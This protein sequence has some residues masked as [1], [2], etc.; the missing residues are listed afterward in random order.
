[1]PVDSDP[2]V[3]VLVPGGVVV[4]PGGVVVLVLVLGGGRV[5]VETGSPLVEV[6]ST[7]VVPPCPSTATDGP[8]PT[9]RTR[10]AAPARRSS[11]L[12]V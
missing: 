4:V 8:H 10:A 3:V 11:M 7:S 5:L 2:D 9:N 12:G 1:M 6:C